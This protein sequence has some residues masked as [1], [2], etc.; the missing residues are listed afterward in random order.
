[1]P[2]VDLQIDAFVVGVRL[3]SPLIAVA[4]LVQAGLGVVSRAAP[5]VQIFSVGFG[6][7]FVSTT[8]VFI[9]TAGD[10]M[11][12]LAAHFGRLGGI[13]DALLSQAFQ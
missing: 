5:S 13:V 8:L 9:D 4:L 7:L 1:M 12:G 2:L 10:M 6:V 3:A 11:S